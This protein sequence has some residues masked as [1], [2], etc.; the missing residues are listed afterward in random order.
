VTMCGP[1][2]RVRERLEGYREA[3]VGTLIVSP[4]AWDIDQRKRTIRDL[5]EML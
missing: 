5:A 2:D 1:R 3:G 4:M